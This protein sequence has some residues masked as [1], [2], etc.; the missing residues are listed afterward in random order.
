[1]VRANQTEIFRNKR[2]ALGGTAQVEHVSKQKRVGHEKKKHDHKRLNI[3]IGKQIL[4]TRT[5]T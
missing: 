5:I 4:P 3:F 1:M 2:T